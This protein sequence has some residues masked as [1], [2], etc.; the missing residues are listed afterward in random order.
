M[1]RTYV[2][3]IVGVWFLTAPAHAQ[4][5]TFLT[6]LVKDPME[7]AVSGASISIVN[8]DTGFRR[9]ALSN[10][11]GR[12]TLASLQPGYYKV[13]VRKEG[14]RSVVRTRL[15]LDVSE[16]AQVDFQLLLGS[17]SETITVESGASPLQTEDASIGT[18]VNRDWVDR[19]PLNGRGLASL[20]DLAPGTL[21]T[22]ATRGE[23]GQFSASGQRPNANYFT[24]DGV[25]LNTGV[26]GGGQPAQPAG[27]TLPGMTAFG[28]FHN[29]VTLDA[30]EEFRIQTSTTGATLARLPGAQI[31]LSTRSGTNELHGSAAFHGRHERFSANDWFANRH[32]LGT[33][34]N[35]VS[36]FAGSLGGPLVKDRTFFFA[37]YEWLRFRQPATWRTPVPLEEMRQSA[38]AWSAPLLTLYPQANGAS[39]GNGTGEWI[40]QSVRPSGMS[41]TSLRIDHALTQRMTLFGRVSRTPSESDFGSAQ[42]NQL[43]AEFHSASLGWNWQLGPGIVNDLRFSSTGASASSAWRQQQPL[44]ECAFHELASVVFSSKTNCGSLFRFAASGLGQIVSGQENEYRQPQ[45]NLVE[46]LTIAWDSH[47][48]QLGGD[49]RRMTPQRPASGNIFTVMSDSLA[50][51]L[52]LRNL[53]ISETELKPNRIGMQELSLFAQDNWRPTARLTMTPGVRWEYGPPP[54]AQNPIQ[55]DRRPSDLFGPRADPPLWKSRLTN[56]APRLGLAYRLDQEGRT[57]L[58]GGAGLYFDSSLAA[59]SDLLNGIP[60]TLWQVASPLP[61]TTGSMRSLISYGFPADLRLPKVWQ[62]NASLERSLNG[63]NVLS[64]AYVGSAGRL[65]LRREVDGALGSNLVRSAELTNRGESNY[66]GLQV[67]LRRRMSRHLQ[68][69]VSYSWSHSLDNASTDSMLHWAGDGYAPRNDYGS[70][71][72]DARHALS[73][74]FRA[75][76][77]TRH[78][79]LLRAWSMQGFF[80]AR[81]GFPINVQLAEAAMGAS[82]ANIFRPDL[83]AGAPLWIAS[84]GSPGGRELNR[85]A[86]VEPGGVRQGT[87]GRNAIAGLGMAQTDLSLS[88]EFAFGARQRLQFRLDAFNVFNNAQFGDPVRFL[89]SPLFGQSSS[90]LN[91]MLGTGTPASGLS[92]NFQTGGPRSMQASLRWRF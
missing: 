20:L 73:A 1:L 27:G 67:Q 35:R 89:A 65:L 75:E 29:L 76:S 4:Q 43:R 19:L 28:S 18:L 69:V 33:A 64:M 66:H 42:V 45:I 40:G 2:V 24:I 5:Y 52:A 44:A 80:R 63:S 74:A 30:L 57:V 50:D 82:F 8:E 15:K 47:Q 87:L 78:S 13:L 68:A 16:P 88:R 58:R 77:G 51:L 49:Y 90:M 48:L 62:W 86:F 39:L 71:D 36:N 79:P 84:A 54:V 32:A 41:S 61:E 25:S 34:P 59:A 56:F 37:A 83:V 53:W 7:R 11:Q 46:N 9:L 70:S 17:V 85:A 6:G 14:F 38:P 72:F 91:V 10:S 3:A 26:L 21:A 31:S 55:R 92:P 60:F 23:A 81:T 12:Y 22:P